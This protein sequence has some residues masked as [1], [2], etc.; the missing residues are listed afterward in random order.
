[1][2]Q[3]VIL[4]ATIQ[5]GSGLHDALKADLLEIASLTRREAG[6][7]QFDIHED[8][9]TPGVFILWEH[10]ASQA[11]FDRHLAMPYTRDYFAKGH[12]LATHVVPLKRLK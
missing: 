2:G 3:E 1:M 5:A 10:F 9:Q 6:C 8:E 11:D 7:I 4:M 12:A